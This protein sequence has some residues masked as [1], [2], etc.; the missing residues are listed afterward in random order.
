MHNYSNTYYNNVCF[1]FCFL[2]KILDRNERGQLTAKEFQELFDSISRQSRTMV[3]ETGLWGVIRGVIR[4][5]KQCLWI[6]ILFFSS[7]F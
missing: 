1:F 7:I 6:T 3:S 5:R 4:D 2:Y